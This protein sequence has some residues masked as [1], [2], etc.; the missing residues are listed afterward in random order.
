MHGGGGGG[1]KIYI[2]L[3]LGLQGVLVEMGTYG[4]QS[5]V[6]MLIRRGCSTEE[7]KIEKEQF[8]KMTNN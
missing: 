4:R 5:F 7:L 3:R 6:Q 1:G 8:E 2:F